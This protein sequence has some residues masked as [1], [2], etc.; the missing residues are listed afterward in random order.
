MNSGGLT[1]GEG[2]GHHTLFLP[3]SFFPCTAG[4]GAV[5]VPFFG[6]PGGTS[7]IGGRFQISQGQNEQHEGWNG[8]IAITATDVA[9]NPEIVIPGEIFPPSQV[10]EGGKIR[11]LSDT[12]SFSM[13]S[14]LINNIK[15]LLLWSG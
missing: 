7:F 5:T 15:R 2:T 1:L 13:D 10:Y 14:N 3:K 9:D 12:I 8:L 4:T 11:K 6:I